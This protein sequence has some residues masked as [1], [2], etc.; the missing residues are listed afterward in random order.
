M[1]Q[2]KKNMLTSVDNKY[3]ILVFSKDMKLNDYP[4]VNNAKD[5]NVS[6]IKLTLTARRLHI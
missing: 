1:N 2:K 3:R 6:E 4:L 5:Q